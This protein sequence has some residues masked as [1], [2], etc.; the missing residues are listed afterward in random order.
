M[1]KKDYI[2]KLMDAL[3]GYWPLARGM[4]ILIEGNALNDEAVDSLV[5]IFSKTID[6][7]N[8]KVVKEKLEKSKEYLENLKKIERNAE[9]QDKKDIQKLDEMLKNF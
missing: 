9:E 7:V 1:T 2:L 4:K 8:D 3:M 6:A 5:D